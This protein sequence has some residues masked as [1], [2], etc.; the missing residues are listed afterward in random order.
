MDGLRDI[1]RTE[2]YRSFLEVLKQRVTSAQYEALKAVNRELIALYWDIGH[3]IV[4]KQAQFGWG[5]HIIERLAKDL[6]I[7]FE[8][9]AGFSVRNLR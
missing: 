1:Q 7:E 8:G 4:E 3:I 9:V 5:E 2:D 6:Q